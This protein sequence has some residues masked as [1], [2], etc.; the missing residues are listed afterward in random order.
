MG[1]GT[2]LEQRD[3]T[4][5]FSR[6]LIFL[7]STMESVKTNSE[8]QDLVRSLN[9]KI[10]SSVLEVKL[11]R[12]PVQVMVEALWSVHLN[13]T[14]VQAGIASW[15]I[16]CGNGTPVIY[17]DVSTAVCWIDQAVTCHYGNN[18]SFFGFKKDVCE[19]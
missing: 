12:T 1:A 14:Y 6:R 10:I 2:T 18:K 3:R 13:H 7:W 19:T 9:F 8:P 15:G 17:A 16:G 4:R 11:E 5:W